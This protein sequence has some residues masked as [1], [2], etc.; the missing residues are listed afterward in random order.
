MGCYKGYNWKRRLVESSLLAGTYV[1]IVTAIQNF[2][3]EDFYMDQT[4]IY[5]GVGVLTLGMVYPENNLEKIV[6]KE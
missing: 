2:T 6:N 4:T 1:G 3:S 5:L